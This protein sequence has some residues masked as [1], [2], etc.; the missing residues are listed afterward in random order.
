MANPRGEF[1]I[2]LVF[3]GL[4]LVGLY[5]TSR[6]DLA[7]SSDLETFSGPR[8]YPG[9]ILSI[10]L[11]FFAGSAAIQLRNLFRRTAG[12]SEYQEFIGARALWSL[13]LFIALLGFVLL[14][15]EVGY[16]LTMVPLLTVV[17][18]LCG[19]ANK[20][21]ALIVAICLTTACLIIF[22]YGLAT[23]LPE[24][25]FGIDAVI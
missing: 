2:T 4:V 20:T 25:L 18:L 24:G 16:I 17:A 7:F 21:K 6:I 13:A 12:S 22:R 15:E 8:A 19:A 3:I 11:L 1:A 23:V 14:F 10:M 9:L 5:L